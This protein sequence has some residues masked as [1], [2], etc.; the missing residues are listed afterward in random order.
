[1]NT[2]SIAAFVL[3]TLIAA[4]AFAD[5]DIP[6]SDQP[7][8][9]ATQPDGLSRAQVRA[10]LVQLEKAGYNPA[11]G[12][13][14]RYPDDIQAAEAKVA[15]QNEMTSS[16]GGVAGGVSAYAAPAAVGAGAYGGMTSLYA[17]H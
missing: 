5:G 11:N 13:D 7:A 6:N 12:E 9:V 15:T 17:H 3:A 10:Q 8:A 1:M 16:H 2:K 4:P 14:I